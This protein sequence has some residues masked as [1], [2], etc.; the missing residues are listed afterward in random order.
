MYFG[1]AFQVSDPNTHQ[2][3]AATL[4]RLDG[5]LMI[6]DLQNHL[7]SRRAK[8]RSCSNIFWITPDLIQE[9]QRILA[10]KIDAWLDG[11]ASR[12]PYSVAH[13]GGVIFKDN[14]WIGDEPGQGLTCATFIVELFK[15]L[16]IPFIDIET[17]ESRV[18]DT[19]WAERILSLI[20]HSMS[21][22]HVEAQRNRIGDKVRVRPSDI[23]AAGHLIHQSMEN[24]LH[25][26]VVAPISTEVEE[27]LLAPKTLSLSPINQPTLPIQ[28]AAIG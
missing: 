14:I 4:Y 26:K 1:L 12:I 5:C 11:N 22:E 24:P 28:A 17:W 6:G 27:A 18:G 16:G 8:A 19:E 25:F 13:P 9:E 20:S 10:A 21:P 2:L 7:I 23:A 15:E 3:H